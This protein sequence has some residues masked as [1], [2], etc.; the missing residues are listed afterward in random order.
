MGLGAKSYCM[1][2]FSVRIPDIITLVFL[3]IF[4]TSH[5]Q[6]ECVEKVM[7][8]KEIRGN[9]SEQMLTVN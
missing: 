6:T 1:C 3:C 7:E 9:K 8:E 4:L 5:V 2:F